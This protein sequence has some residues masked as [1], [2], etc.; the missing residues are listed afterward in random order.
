MDT[1]L[2]RKTAGKSKRPAARRVNHDCKILPGVAKIQAPESPPPQVSLAGTKTARNA[3]F[4]PVAKMLT[5][6]P[7]DPLA[8]NGM[9][10][11]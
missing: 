3:R 8:K 5:A 1:P 4:P 10:G 9:M 2:P 7:C 6:E 11:P